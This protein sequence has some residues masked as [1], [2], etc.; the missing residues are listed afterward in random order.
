ME[1]QRSKKRKGHRKR[2]RRTET[3]RLE[4]IEAKKH[5]QTEM[6]RGRGWIVSLTRT[7]CNSLLA[8]K[9]ELVRITQ[10][11]GQKTDGAYAWKS[12]FVSR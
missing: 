10:G 11:L 3:E 7:I 8:F 6:D 1:V 5:R 12:E 9:V 2:D 4:D